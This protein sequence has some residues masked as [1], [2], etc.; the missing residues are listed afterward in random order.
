MAESDEFMAGDL[1]RHGL[2][3]GFDNAA[4]DYQRT[5]S[6]C[7]PELFDDLI[8]RAGLRAG[9]RVIE[10]GCG[11]GQATVPLAQRGLAVT[12]GEL[13]ATRSHRPPPPDPRSGLPR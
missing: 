5:R 4:E 7:P 3:A 12:T 6:V 2:R 8:D 9:N 13:G 11:T 10:I 1:R